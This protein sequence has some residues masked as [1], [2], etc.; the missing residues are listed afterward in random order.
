MASAQRATGNVRTR[1]CY[2][3]DERQLKGGVS[4]MEDYTYHFSALAIGVGRHM[5]E[6]VSRCLEQT[7]AGYLPLSIGGKAA[8]RQS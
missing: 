8:A 5:L 4:F 6:S 2:E 7:Q 3:G 1:S